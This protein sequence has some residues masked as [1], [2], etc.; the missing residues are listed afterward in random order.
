MQKK[1]TK[2]KVPEHIG[3]VISGSR[4]WAKERNLPEKEGHKK[5]FQRMSECPKWFFEKGVRYLSIFA[6]SNEVW[7]REQEEVS[8]FMK[9]LKQYLLNE[10]EK[11]GEGSYRVLVSGRVDELPGDLPALVSE[12]EASSK[13][14]KKGTL[15]L[16][17]NYNGRTE[18]IDM[19][20]KVVEKK[21]SSEQIHEGILRKYL[22]HG[23]VPDSDIIQ[24]FSGEKKLSAF[25]TWQSTQ[26]KLIFSEKFW[27]DF[28]SIDI[29]N[30]L[31]EWQSKSSVTESR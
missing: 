13:I 31:K 21:F 27:P 20:K 23:E 17:L 18:I 12:L 6:F 16:C 14:G 30:I 22:Y 4:R 19:V 9:L 24:F 10:I 29:E 28:E 15:H 8:I 7:A 3:L 25:L 11:A 1:E 2:I 26:S 5:S